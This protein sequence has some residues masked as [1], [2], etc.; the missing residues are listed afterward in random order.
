MKAIPMRRA[1]VFLLLIFLLLPG[2]GS[3]LKG[4][5]LQ[6]SG[7]SSGGDVI[8]DANNPWFVGN[9]HKVAYCLDHDPVS[10]SASRAVIESAIKKAFE[11][12]HEEFIRLHDSFYV[13]DGLGLQEFVS[14]PCDGNEDI[15]FQFGAGTLTQGQKD[16]LVPLQ[17][18]VGVTV[19]TSYDEVALR[20]KGYVYIASDKGENKF[21]VG[22]HLNSEPWTH[23]GL[24]LRVLIHEIGHT[25][26][27]AH[28][29]GK[30]MDL[31]PM[32]MNL[33]SERYPE[34]ILEKNTAGEF[35]STELSSL[36][37]FF[38]PPRQYEL[39]SLSDRARQWLLLPAD[40]SCV[41]FRYQFQQENV[42]ILARSEKDGTLSDYGVLQVKSAVKVDQAFS[43]SI[44]LNPKQK[45]FPLSEFPDEMRGRLESGLLPAAST[46]DFELEGTL[47]IGKALPRPGF[48]KY[49]VESFKLIGLADSVTLKTILE[50]PG[51]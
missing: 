6:G 18:H 38:A 30:G 16:F 1:Y 2:C 8:N 32:Q 50:Y 23:E 33:M 9:V 3:S 39:C 17:K 34:H 31:N 20:G 40:K 26:G 36:G 24:L 12:W 48:I 35:L 43:I 47:V 44:R 37:S 21:D 51:P 28:L 13:L 25:L 15:R 41:I 22:S 42:A 10:V 7:V 45:V 4:P 46:H 14:I 27:I 19:R 49:G 29:G 11:F 5:A